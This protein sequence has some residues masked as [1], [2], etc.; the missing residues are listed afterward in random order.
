MSCVL[1]VTDSLASRTVSGPE[2]FTSWSELIPDCR[3]VFMGK[4]AGLSRESENAKRKGTVCQEMHLES[5][6]QSPLG[7][8]FAKGQGA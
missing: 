3:C 4:S 8:S 7:D 2:M 5:L 1:S 6:K